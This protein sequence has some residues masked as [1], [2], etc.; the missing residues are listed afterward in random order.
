MGDVPKVLFYAWN[1]MGAGH[2]TRLVSIA[3]ALRRLAH[4][5]NCNLEIW[6]ITTSEAIKI[7]FNERF[8]TLKF[9]SVEVATEFG[10]QRASHLRLGRAWVRQAFKL[11]KP[12]MV[13]VD[14]FPRGFFNEL[15]T[16]LESVPKKVIV[17]RPSKASFEQQPAVV[18]AL[19]L[20]DLILVSE[21]PEHANLNF[22]AEIQQKIRFLG[23]VIIRE[24]EEIMPRDVARA[25]LGAI[26]GQK[27][28]YLSA[29]GGGDDDAESMLHSWIDW[30]SATEHLLVVGAGPLYRGRV[31]YGRNIVWT[32]RV[33]ICELM[34]AFD[35]AICAAG[36]MSFNELMYFG[37][38]TIFIPRK[39]QTDDQ[40]A[41]ACR[42]EQEKTAMVVRFPT[43]TKLVNNIARLCTKKGS[44]MRMN[45]L[46]IY[47]KNYA[48]DFANEIY[49][50]L[51]AQS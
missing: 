44:E 39:R 22:S 31:Q 10:F 30:L 35:A 8:P 20:Y 41:R 18:Q 5:R 26:P 14:S 23:P 43:S 51:A 7:A 4:E 36:Y 40:F 24:R 48:A 2:L 28:I 17:Y 1:G 29:G 38:P 42:A 9:P 34:N 13:V 3:R 49:N 33:P 16:L 32:D 46:R 27:I 11:L 21:R 45:A 47:G 37:V 12:D 25:V 50:L 19:D 15:P 6:V